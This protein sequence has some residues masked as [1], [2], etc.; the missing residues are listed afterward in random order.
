MKNFISNTLEVKKLFNAKKIK[1]V[2]LWH[3]KKYLKNNKTQLYKEKNAYNKNKLKKMSFMLPL[4]SSNVLTM[5]TEI[6]PD[7]DFQNISKE[8]LLLLGIAW[9]NGYRSNEV[10][11][12]TNTKTP[13]KNLTQ[14]NLVTHNK[15]LSF[16]GFQVLKKRILMLTHNFRELETSH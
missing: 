13:I 14:S 16:L 1:R 9:T 7:V 4:F 15:E 6:K 3:I 10:I 11:N 8:K 12:F 2:A 5:V